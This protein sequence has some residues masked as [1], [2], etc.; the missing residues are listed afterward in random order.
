VL[1]M[2]RLRKTLRPTEVTQQYGILATITPIPFRKAHFSDS[3]SGLCAPPPLMESVC[4]IYVNPISNT[5]IL[6]SIFLRP[7]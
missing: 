6:L 3:G 2:L 4:G 5:P 7:N 1:R